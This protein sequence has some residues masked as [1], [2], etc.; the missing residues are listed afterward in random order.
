MFQ[1]FLAQFT[2]FI[3][4]ENEMEP[5]D[6]IFVPGNPFP[7]MAEEAA[8]LWKAGLAP[9]ILP[10]GYHALLEEHFQGVCDRTGR[11][12]GTFKS[13]WEFLNTVL[14]TCGVP[15]ACVLKED[16]ASYTYENAIRSREVTDRLGLEIKKAIIC[17]HAYHAR[18]CLLYYQL[19]FPE[20]QL[21]IRP[22]N[23]GINR[24][25]WYQTEKGIDTVLGEIE[26]CGGQFHK[27]LR[28]L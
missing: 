15:S 17:C 2:D 5:S 8:R 18:R 11:Y 19:L 6:I 22:V 24:E 16:T 28:D 26:R 7:Q 20:T 14:V 10:S 9:L 3:F 13:E 23:T 21:L 25:N 4:V 27:I 12:Q 1:R